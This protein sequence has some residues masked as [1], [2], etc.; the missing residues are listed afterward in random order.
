MILFAE[1]QIIQGPGVAKKGRF[2]YILI[3][4]GEHY[5]SYLTSLYSN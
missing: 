3:V 4:N 5:V 2:F 1:L